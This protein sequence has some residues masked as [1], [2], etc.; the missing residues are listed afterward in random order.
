[1]DEGATPV[2]QT[3]RCS[4]SDAGERPPGLQ[5]RG[6]EPWEMCLSSILKDGQLFGYEKQMMVFR[7]CLNYLFLH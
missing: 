4:R 2:A 1:M 6:E 3:A 5:D 7:G